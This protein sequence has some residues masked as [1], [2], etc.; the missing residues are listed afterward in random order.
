MEGNKVL[1]RINSR[2]FQFYLLR[3]LPLA[4]IAG[5]KT[6][7]VNFQ[8]AE[9]YMKFRWINQNPFGSIYFAALCMGGEFSTGIIA[10]AIILNSDAKMSM[11]LLN[12]EANFIKKAKGVVVFKCFD[13]PSLNSAIESAINS[14]EAT[15]CTAYSEAIN[16]YGDVIATFRCK[17]AFRLK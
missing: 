10:Q 9:I 17:W 11:L 14:I 4:Y 13:G 6:R 5:V 2:L 7:Y 8:E 1:Q 16:E 15:E 12:I 3:H